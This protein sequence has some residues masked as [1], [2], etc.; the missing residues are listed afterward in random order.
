MEER[1]KEQHI[2][3]DMYEDM[4]IKPT[5]LYESQKIIKIIKLPR[6]VETK[7]SMKTAIQRER[8]SS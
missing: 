7:S 1:T 6:E 8:E 5:I 2:M 4:M 3:T